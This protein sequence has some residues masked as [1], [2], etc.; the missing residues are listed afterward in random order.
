MAATRSAHAD[1]HSRC[2]GLTTAEGTGCRD[3]AASKGSSGNPGSEVPLSNAVA[4][5]A[6]RE[7]G[8]PARVIARAGL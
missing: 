8:V 4:A 5:A 2:R 6:L 1:A 7:V 3:T